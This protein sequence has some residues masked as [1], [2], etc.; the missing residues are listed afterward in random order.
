MTRARDGLYLLCS[1]DPSEVVAAGL[2]CFEVI[3]S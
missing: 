2:D 3:D 1:G